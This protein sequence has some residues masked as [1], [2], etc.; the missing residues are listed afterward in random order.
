MNDIKTVIETCHKTRNLLPLRA[1][2]IGG[3][4]ENT[5]RRAAYRLLLDI[6]KSYTPTISPKYD[7]HDIEQIRKDVN[8]CYSYINVP[9]FREKKKNQLLRVLACLFEKNT[10]LIY[11]QGFNDIAIMVLSFS[12]EPLALQIL[13]KLGT[14]LLKM[15]MGKGLDG[16]ETLLLFC[17]SLLRI[18]DDSIFKHFERYDIQVAL[19]TSH[20]MTLFAN[21]VSTFEDGLRF[22]DFFIASHPLMPIYTIISL[23]VLEKAKMTKKNLEPSV[24]QSILQET[25]FSIDQ[26][27]TNAVAIYKKYPPNVVLEMDKN[28]EI[29]EEC[30][31]L[32]PSVSF[33]YPFPSF[34]FYNPISLIQYTNHLTQYRGRS[35]AAR[36]LKELSLAAYIGMKILID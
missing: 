23:I 28:L 30:D 31:Y 7:Y 27:I 12:R 18:V 2:S 35:L 14:G 21:N 20:I 4:G 34:P 15:Y 33:P 17:E 10:D 19:F 3:Y 1:R 32:S 36:I 29:S 13:E 6:P 16:M 8:R 9:D 24:V 26:I 22:L 11:Y 5:D 25:E